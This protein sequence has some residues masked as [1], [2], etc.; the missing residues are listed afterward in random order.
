MYVG[1][2]ASALVTY[3]AKI[4]TV[5]DSVAQGLA[6]D[7]AG[8][9]LAKRL[10]DANFSVEVQKVVEDGIYSVGAALRD[11]TEGFH[12]VVVT[13]GGT[14]FAERDHTPEATA[15]VLDRPAPGLAEAMR[16]ADPAGRLSRAVAGT[17]G[18]ALILNTPGSPG[19]AVQFLEAVLDVLPHA[20]D[21][22]A[23]TPGHGHEH[24][25]PHSREPA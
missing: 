7:V 14:G 15:A 9:A 13:T 23:G 6:D 20:L 19:G 1:P 5:S 8:A 16:L 4:L 12:G 11:L 22:L 10:V 24:S 18:R 2:V 3:A 25:R 21:V 17:R